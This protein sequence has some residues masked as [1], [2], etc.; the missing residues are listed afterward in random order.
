MNDSLTRPLYDC[1]KF[2]MGK[3]RIILNINWDRR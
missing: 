3:A 1:N 2:K